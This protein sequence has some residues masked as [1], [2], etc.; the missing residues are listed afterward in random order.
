MLPD[1]LSEKKE[2]IDFVG[3]VIFGVSGIFC[4]YSLITGEIIG[5]DNQ[6]IIAGFVMGIILFIT[7]IFLEKRV[8]Y[9]LVDFSLFKSSLFSIGILCTFIC[10]IVI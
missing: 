6:V 4:F 9:T 8:K 2:D 10:Y 5:Y 1:Q 3:A 7:F